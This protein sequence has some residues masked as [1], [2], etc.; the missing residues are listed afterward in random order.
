[1]VLAPVRHT[2]P[3]GTVWPNATRP[4]SDGREYVRSMYDVEKLWRMCVAG[5][6]GG[7]VSLV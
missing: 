4:R 7:A 1:M 5:L 3:L 2:V 6:S